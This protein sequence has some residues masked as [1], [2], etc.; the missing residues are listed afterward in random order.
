MNAIL[1]NMDIQFRQIHISLP[2]V[3]IKVALSKP[4]LLK[5]GFFVKGTAYTPQQTT[6]DLALQSIRIDRH[7]DVGAH[8]E[9]IHFNVTA[10]TALN[11]GHAGGKGGCTT[12][13][14]SHRDT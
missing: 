1:N 5:H 3:T 11:N 7:T 14:G 13:R 8:R 9:L 6:L 12:F 10:C 4:P 2:L